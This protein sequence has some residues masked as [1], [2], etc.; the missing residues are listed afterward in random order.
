MKY[1]NPQGMSKS[2][3]AAQPLQPSRWIV[4]VSA[5]S[6]KK[7]RNN[8]RRYKLPLKYTV[9][10]TGNKCLEVDGVAYLCFAYGSA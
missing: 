9:F 3:E 4:T 8:A 6:L 10:E 2:L 1:T 5:K 7:L